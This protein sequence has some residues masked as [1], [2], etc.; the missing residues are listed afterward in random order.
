MS[1]IICSLLTTEYICIRVH[2]RVRARAHIFTAYACVHLQAMYVCVIRQII[3]TLILSFLFTVRGQSLALPRLSSAS[4]PAPSPDSVER[5]NACSHYLN[6][7][8]QIK[9]NQIKYLYNYSYIY[10]TLTGNNRAACR[11]EEIMT[12]ACRHT[13]AVCMLEL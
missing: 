9:S 3:H 13:H 8:L 11:S 1:V 2:M 12:T 10:I 6:F 7:I 5:A 4:A